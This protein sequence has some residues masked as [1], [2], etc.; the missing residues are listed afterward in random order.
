MSMEKV[1]QGIDQACFL[2]TTVM[3]CV[4]KGNL[5]VDCFK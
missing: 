3:V 1:R 2:H 4:V 5:R